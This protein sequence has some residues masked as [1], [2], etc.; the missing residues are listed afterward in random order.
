MRSHYDNILCYC[1]DYTSVDIIQLDEK[2][3]SRHIVQDKENNLVAGI[4][5]NPNEGEPY[6]LINLSKQKDYDV[7]IPLINGETIKWK[8]YAPQKSINEWIKIGKV[9][10]GSKKVPYIKSY[11]KDELQGQRPSNIITQEYGTSKAGTKDMDVIFG[12][13]KIFPYP[14]PAVLIKRLIQIGSTKDSIILDFFSGSS[15]TAHAVFMMNEEDQGSRHF[16][17]VQLP[18]ETM[19]GSIANEYGFI[20]ICELGKERIRRVSKEYNNQSTIDGGQ[21]DTGFKVFKLDSSN[22]K[23]WSPDSDIRNSLL[24]FEDNLI[25]DSDRYEMDV[26]FEILLKLGL[27]LNSNI[28]EKQNYYSV[29]NGTLM[30]CLKDVASMDVP[31]AMIDEFKEKEPLVWK[32]VFK[33]NGFASDDVKANVRETLK[34]AGLQEGSFITL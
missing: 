12:N 30:I 27:D 21:I 26:V 23:K 32:V 25:S 3:T 15:T 9:F 33:D 34:M 17:C 1:K 19:P 20:N 2:D 10:V 16:I 14:K 29:E 22:I 6:Q 28:E 8:S 11:L 5:S 4:T 13:S 24:S 18:E 31:Q 7:E